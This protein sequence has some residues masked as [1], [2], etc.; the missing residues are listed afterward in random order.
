M[1]NGNLN[2]FWAQNKFAIG[3]ALPKGIDALAQVLQASAETF[4]HEGAGRSRLLIDPREDF[5]CVYFV[6]SS[7]DWLPES[8]RMPPQV[9]WSGLM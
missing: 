7:I 2:E 3:Q 5:I 1:G 8:V 4:G 9:I 6:P